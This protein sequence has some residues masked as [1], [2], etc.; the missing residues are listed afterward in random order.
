MSATPTLSELCFR[1]HLLYALFNCFHSNCELHKHYSRDTTRLITQTYDSFLVASPSWVIEWLN[2]VYIN[3]WRRVNIAAITH[4][5]SPSMSLQVKLSVS[6]FI[7][8]QIPIFSSIFVF[9]RVYIFS[10]PS[11]FVYEFRR[12]VSHFSCVDLLHT[13]THTHDGD[14]FN[15]M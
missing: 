8:K 11:S 14:C 5:T 2:V 7:S 3:V 1:I 12:V 4:D 6:I 9:V 10:L 15:L 13:F